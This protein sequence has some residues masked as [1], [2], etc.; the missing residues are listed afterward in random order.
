MNEEEKEHHLC[1]HSE[2]LAI[3]LGL[4]NTP[5][6]TPLIITKN[7]RVCLDCHNASK[8]ISILYNREI[9]VKDAN[10]FHHFKNGKCSSCS[11]YW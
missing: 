3:G 9:T 7:L 6:G 8:I 2:K 1:S 5:P 4:I 11:D 10:R